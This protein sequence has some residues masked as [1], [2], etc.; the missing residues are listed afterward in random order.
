MNRCR[1]LWTALLVFCMVFQLGVLP[2]QAA[3][4]KEPYR[5]RTLNSLWASRF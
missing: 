3:E 2:S 4:E 1:K 5:F